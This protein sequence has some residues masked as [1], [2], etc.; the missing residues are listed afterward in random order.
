MTNRFLS[1]LEA[2]GRDFKKRLDVIL[3]IAETAG[4]AA[5]AMFIPALGPIFNN[6]V[7]AVVVAEQAAA[8]AGKQNGSGAQKAAAVIG[9]IGP[10]I[11]VALEDAGKAADDAAVQRYLDAV[12]T[13]LNIIPAP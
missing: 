7:H 4:E 12:V 11:K 2:A 6:T 8:A 1:F 10:L 5:V 9:L 13:I 3:P